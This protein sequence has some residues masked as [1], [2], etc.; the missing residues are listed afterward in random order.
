MKSIEEGLTFQRGGRGEDVLLACE[1]ASM[2]KEQDSRSG[3]RADGIMAAILGELGR[4]V[5]NF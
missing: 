3:N 1:R 4:H 5:E 2:D